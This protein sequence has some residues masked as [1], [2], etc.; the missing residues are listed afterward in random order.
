M[1][2]CE[3]CYKEQA[4]IL[5]YESQGGRSSQ[6]S[7]CPACA[8][9]KGFSALYLP[10]LKS[11]KGLNI[12]AAPERV[13]KPKAESPRIAELR[14]RLEFAVLTEAFEEAAR[15]RDLIK[16]DAFLSPLR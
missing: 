16:Q 6:V 4:N 9:E 5:Y 2:T 12:E 14:A 11:I 15:L 13:N 8:A 7:L 10:S 1:K 3:S